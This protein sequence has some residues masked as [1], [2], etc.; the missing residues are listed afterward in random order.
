MESLV[1]DFLKQKKFAV[2]G[3]L[4]RKRMPGKNYKESLASARGRK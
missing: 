4:N 1:K 3:S 2:V